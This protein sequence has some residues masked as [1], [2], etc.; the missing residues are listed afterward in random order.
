MPYIDKHLRWD[1]DDKIDEIL[2]LIREDNRPEGEFNYVITRIAIDIFKRD[3]SY[4][5]GNAIMGVLDCAA[6]E[7]YRRHL[8]PYE[9]AKML[10]NG[11]VE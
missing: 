10:E 1:L 7:F 8:A 6:R 3:R 5:T 2:D 9:D 11:D 4:K